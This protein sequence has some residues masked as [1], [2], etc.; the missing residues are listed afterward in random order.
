MPNIRI[1]Q[2]VA[3]RVVFKA[4]LTDGVT[5]ATGK[6]LA[7][8]ISKN[9][10]AFANPAAG[11]TNTTEIANG[12]YYADLGTGDPDTLGPLI[13]RA[14]SATTDPSE[15]VF[16]V[17]NAHNQGFD[18]TP[19]A[20]AE[21]AGGLF[22]RGTGAGQI[23]QDANGRIDANLKSIL[24]TALTETAGQIA[25]GFKKLFD[26][27]APV[28]TA[29]S[30]NQTGDAF[31]RQ[32]APAGASMSADILAVK[33]DTA[34][35]KLKTD[36]I[37]AGGPP[38]ATDYTT[39]RA[40]KLDNLDAAI[41]TRTKP[42]DTQ[43]AVTTVT[44]LT[45]APTAGDFN[46][47]MKTSLNAATPASVTGAVG[48]VT[49]AVGSVTGNVGGNVVGNVNGNVAG[50][51]ASVTGDVGITQAGADKVWGSAARSLTSFG[52]LVADVAAA[53]WAAGT[54][55]LTAFG[56]TVTASPDSNVAL[57]KAKT[58]LIP[59]V[60]ADETLIINAT[61][62][63]MS[64][65]AAVAAKTNNLPASPAAVGSAMTLSGAYDAAKTAAQVGD[66]PT[67]I[68]NA[69]ALLDRP[70][71]IETGLT[72][73]QAHRLQAA[74][75]AGRVLGA[76]TTTVTIRNAVA[77]DTDRIVATVDAAGNRV[78]VVLDVA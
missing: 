61:N 38:A 71:A 17:A 26:V 16:E 21:A 1:P 77:D 76:D 78:A 39:A 70:D 6:T 22:T 33:G 55:T 13:V 54:R 48:S 25:A 56:F 73:R 67:A 42:A 15:A 52:T 10:G 46:A 32:G 66:I 23:N 60:P 8:T 74:A 49:G 11:A 64:S 29:A 12:W 72:L 53:V 34:A 57:I 45:N 44:N 69:D 51:V 59:A 63:I 20:A 14:T 3:K 65:V 37:P 27:A 28:L 43:A 24:G 35:V 5:E 36:L 41:S 75:A 7:V 50:S 2:S 47:T 18:G 19:N 58:D 9:G 31:A 68:E 4:Y 62:A 30:V 40:A